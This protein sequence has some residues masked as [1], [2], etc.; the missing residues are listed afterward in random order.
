MESKYIS[1]SND[2]NCTSTK[3]ITELIGRI[4][5]FSNGKE[6]IVFP[7]SVDQY[8][9]VAKIWHGTLSP[10]S[11]AQAAKTWIDSGA[12]IVGGCCRV[13]SAH[14]TTLHVRNLNKL[15]YY[16]TIWMCIILVETMI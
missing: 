5:L 11:C 4:K 2:I 7:N 10:H 12:T 8:D 3:Y 6:I 1:V 13:R 16:A 14:L 15:C 9:P